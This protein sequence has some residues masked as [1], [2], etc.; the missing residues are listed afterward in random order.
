M[1]LYRSNLRKLVRRPATWVTFGLLAALLLLIFL[2][3]GASARQ[4]PTGQAQLAA[5]LFVTFPEAYRLVLAMVL[6]LGGL[7]AVTY[8][9]AVAGSEWSWGTLKS[10]VARGESRSWYTLAGFGAVAT[11]AIAGLVAAS[12]LGVLA[13]I[14]GAIVADVPL[15]GLGDERVLAELPELF[16]RGALSISMQAG[17]GFAIATVAGSQLAGIGVGIGAFFGEQFAGIFVPDIVRWLPFNAAGAVV[18]VEGASGPGGGQMGNALDPGTALVVVTA[19]L[20][21]ALVVAALWTERAEI[22]G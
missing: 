22:G 3:V 14:V 15:D 8:G 18:A 1:R 10:A 13:A 9:A 11:F 16:A 17:I 20:V 12:L 7:L 19:W 2:A 5:R 4:A 6:G 21:G